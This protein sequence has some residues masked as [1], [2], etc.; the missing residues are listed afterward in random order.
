[1]NRGTD[2]A[3]MNF[4]KL[5]SDTYFGI[6]NVREKEHKERGKRKMSRLMIHE[7]TDQLNI[8]KLRW[9]NDGIVRTK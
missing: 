4:E 1:M 7:I 8:K 9:M 2:L 3:R 5:L 6:F